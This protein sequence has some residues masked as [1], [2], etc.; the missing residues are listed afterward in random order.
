MR[1]Y[2]V[3]GFS[4]EVEVPVV[5]VKV[6]APDPERALALAGA[7]EITAGLRLDAVDIGGALS[8]EGVVYE[9]PWPWPGRAG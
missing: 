7:R 1:M 6:R 9:G 5:V 3:K 2:G 4:A 8:T